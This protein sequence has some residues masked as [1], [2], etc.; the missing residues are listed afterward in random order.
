MRS[1]VDTMTIRKL[2]L[3]LALS[4]VLACWGSAFAEA[5]H[6]HVCTGECNHDA[7]AA[8]PAT[9]VEILDGI[10]P[11]DLQKL[12]HKAIQARLKMERDQV[13][14]EIR[15]GLLYDGQDIDAAIAMLNSNPANTQ[16]DNID[17]MLRA[18]AKVDVRFAKAY[19]LFTA[20]KGAEAAEAAKRTI[21]AHSQ[22]STY[23]SA[24]KHY[25]LAESLLKA[26]KPDDAI[27]AYNEIL[28]LMPDRI[29]FAAASASNAAA[30]YEKLGRFR[31]AMEMYSY[32]MRNYGLTMDDASL[33][34]VAA[35]ID[36]F[37][38]IYKDPMNTVAGWMGDVQQRLA[39]VDSGTD[40]RKKQDEIV[41]LLEDMIKTAEEQ[42]QQQEQQ[43][44]QNKKCPG[45]GKKGCPGGKK[46]P[47]AGKGK[48]KG[49]GSKP[50]MAKSKGAQNPTSPMKR[51]MVVPGAV[52]RPDAGEPVRPTDPSGDWATLPPRERD[53]IELL[54]KRL[55]PERYRAAISDYNTR[56]AEGPEKPDRE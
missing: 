8:A 34:V 26:D 16:K 27:D 18:F 6:D 23:F 45:C 1:A 35:K 36:E 28:T 38:E 42:Q 2:A 44:A 50:A 53:R 31:L 29:S 22:E 56:M 5:E 46:C 3:T 47:G 52:K 17:R 25:L 33:N 40:T 54:R 43:E 48:G 37:S 19:R 41:A 12:I 32:C 24:A 13:S 30:T 10:S 21:K 15:R 49:K 39:A 51:S 9:A 11:E 7:P 14:A 20:G 4:V 55:M